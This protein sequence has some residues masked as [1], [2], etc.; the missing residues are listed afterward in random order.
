ML[1][2]SRYLRAVCIWQRS[3]GAC[4][5]D[6]ATIFHPMSE[7]G[8]VSILG[9]KINCVVGILPEERSHEQPLEFD[10]R[11]T[12]DF[13]GVREEMEGHITHGVDYAALASYIERL[14]RASRYRTLEYLIRDL[15]CHMI[16]DHDDMI[17]VELTVRKPQAISKAKC[18]EVKRLIRRR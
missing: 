8:S 10:V 1:L 12:C 17:E 13:A 14:V 11:Y 16:D 5:W 7:L 18:V 2:P 4:D 15:G 9:L 3:Q 6:F